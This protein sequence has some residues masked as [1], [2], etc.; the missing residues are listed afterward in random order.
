[1]KRLMLAAGLLMA[2][3]IAGAGERPGNPDKFPSIGVFYTGQA[4]GGDSTFTSSGLSTTQD[5]T[6]RTG[7]LSVDA[8]FP[9]S[10]SVT[11]QGAIGTSWLTIDAE[12]TSLLNGRKDDLGGLQFSF[13]A[14]FYIH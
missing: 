4:M 14:R 1:M 10:N 8:R 13:G 7:I 3:G 2:A 5:A 9:V 6:L 11:L 12:E